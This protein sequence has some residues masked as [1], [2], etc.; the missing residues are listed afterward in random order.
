MLIEYTAARKKIERE[1]TRLEKTQGEG[2]PAML[3]LGDSLRVAS[4][5]EKARARRDNL[6][7]EVLDGVR[8]RQLYGVQPSR[9]VE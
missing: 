6:I 7:G 5:R 2:S 3:Y 4:D 1:L 9:G 8:L